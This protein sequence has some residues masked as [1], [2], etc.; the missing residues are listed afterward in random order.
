MLKASNHS[1]ENCGKKCR[2]LDHGDKINRALVNSTLNDE[3]LAA[4]I[5][6]TCRNYAHVFDHQVRIFYFFSLS[7]EISFLF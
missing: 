5:A 6:K 7:L 2:N 3:K 1:Y 4:Y